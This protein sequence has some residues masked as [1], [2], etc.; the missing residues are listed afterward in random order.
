MGWKRISRHTAF[1]QGASILRTKSRDKVGTESTVGEPPDRPE[2][3]DGFCG[4]I[5][6]FNSL[7]PKKM[8]AGR[9]VLGDRLGRYMLFTGVGI[10][11]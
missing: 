6:N 5:A 9:L 7:K 2:R 1:Q 3:V 10:F 8:P 11:A 4:L